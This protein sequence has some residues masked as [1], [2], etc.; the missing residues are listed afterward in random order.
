MTRKLSLL[1]LAA[2]TLAGAVPARAQPAQ[3][4]ASEIAALRAQVAELQ[5]R[6]AAL[7]NGR[8]RQV[9]Q[10]Q[11]VAAAS[12]QPPQAVTP[13]DSEEEEEPEI[14]FR[15][16]PQFTAP[17]GWSFKPR[18]RLQYDGA[19]VSSP[20][21]ISD[22]GLGFSN[23][24]R[25]AR[26]GVEGSI[27]GGFGYTFELDFAGE[28]VEVTDAILTYDA[29][30]AVGLTL[31]QHN[32]FQSLEELTSSRFSSFV[33]R[34]AFT[35][36]FNFE[37]RMGLSGTV[38]TGD[39]IAQAGV[40]TDN[41]ADLGDDGNN[42]VSV[43]GR[44]VFAPELSGTRL[45]LGASAHWRDTGDLAATSITRY[46]Q[47]PLVHSTDVRFISTPELGVREETSYGL[48]AAILRGPFHFAG[49]LHWLEA[50][51]LPP[52]P[53]PTFF[54]GYAEIGWFITGETRGYRNGRFDR[55][56]VANPVEQGGAGAF[57]V[58]LRYDR[59]DLNSDGVLGG[60]QDGLQA[61]LIWIPTDYVRFL[62]N[63]ARMSYDDAAIPAA[64][65]DRSYAVDVIGARAQ[66]DF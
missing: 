27:P 35:D 51:T 5:A 19:Y 4:V 33:E 32:N 3:D 56:Q 60:T 29:S 39:L 6:L 62:L 25:R 54:G 18:G 11:P 36:A 26:L 43:D 28:E 44:V 55:T 9:P 21:G 45:H 15:G 59:L 1:L 63:Y 2:T 37:R 64:D 66:I 47:R 17:G 10:V 48:E 46:R 22:P 52:G 24:L 7:E 38:S 57:Q 30:E 16:A 20:A 31:G 61:S 23:E 13:A 65:G 34:A 53:D 41:V 12:F 58:N 40:F 42:S 8:A 49:E 14:R 50:D